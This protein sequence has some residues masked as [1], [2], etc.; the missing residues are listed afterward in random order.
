MHAIGEECRYLNASRLRKEPSICAEN[1]QICLERHDF[2]IAHTP[3]S[4]G[5]FAPKTHAEHVTR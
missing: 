5:R 1:T 4:C 3:S 2:S